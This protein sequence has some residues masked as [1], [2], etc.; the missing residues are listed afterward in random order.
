MYVAIRP[1]N[2][3][4]S[5]ARNSHMASLLFDRPVV[6]WKC[7]YSGPRCGSVA[8]VLCASMTSAPSSSG[9]KSSGSRGTASVVASNAAG[10]S[11][12]SSP[13]AGSVS[14]V[15]VS[16]NG[17][18]L[19]RRAFATLAEL[20]RSLTVCRWDG[21]VGVFRDGRLERPA[22]QAEQQHHDA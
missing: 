2:S 3:R 20:R 12:T 18:Q 21:V 10:A 11:A 14:G 8:F 1:P 22:E 9:T 5:L 19:L 16:A 4:H 15:S 6:V 7:W 17:V 13:G